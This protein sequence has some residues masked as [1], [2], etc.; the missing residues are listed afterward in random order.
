MLLSVVLERATGSSLRQFAERELFGPLGMRDTYFYDDHTEPHPAAGRRAIG[1][2]GGPSGAFTSGVLPNFEQV[3]DGGLFSTVEDVLH[4]DQ[5]FYDGKVGGSALLALMQTPGRLSDGTAIEY[6]FGLMV[7][8][9]AGLRTVVHSGGFMGYRTIIQRFPD[10]RF[11]VIVLCNEGSASPEQLAPAIAD[12][13]LVDAMDRGQR[14]LAGEY[15][16]DELRATWRVDVSGG[17]VRLRGPAGA[18]T[19]TSDGG[20][21]YRVDSPL[22]RA[23]LRFTRAGAAVT[24]LTVNLGPRATGLTFVKR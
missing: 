22:G 10:E 4:W 9:H 13:Y 20:D 7:R 17:R 8:D 15:Y 14:P 24:A 3:G 1:Y 19:M 12:I 23:N 5:N 2:Q 21:A 16:S 11:S 18:A 6:A